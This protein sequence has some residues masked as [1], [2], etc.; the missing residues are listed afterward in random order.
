MALLYSYQS[1]PL[2]SQ[3]QP[4]GRPTAHAPREEKKSTNLR[5][6][7][8]I[9]NARTTPPALAPPPT[10]LYKPAVPRPPPSPGHHQQVIYIPL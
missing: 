2:F 9:P 8:L 3:S 1:P 7:Y 4:V 5:L 6:A 10:Y